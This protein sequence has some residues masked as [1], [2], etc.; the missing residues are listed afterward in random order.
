ML[1][2]GFNNAIVNPFAVP[3]SRNH[4]GTSQVSEMTRDLW[5]VYFQHF[6]EE[7]DANFVVSDQIDQPQAGMIRERFKEKCDAIF[8][9]AHT[10]PCPS[11]PVQNGG[12]LITILTPAEFLF[13]TEFW[14]KIA[15]LSIRF[16]RPK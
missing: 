4:A 10:V 15:I 9:A 3:A 12:L 11:Q 8:F 13:Q 1:V 7:T 14:S 6:H 16:L 2:S 5:L